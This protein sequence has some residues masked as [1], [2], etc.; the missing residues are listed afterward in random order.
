MLVAVA[1]LGL[2]LSGVLAALE[3]GRRAYAIGAARAESQ[4]GARVALDR[5]AR[6]L[7][8]AGAGPL[9]FVAISV[10]ERER[11]VLHRD[12]D[13]DGVTTAR[14]ET[15]TWTLDGTV[16]RRD[17][18]GG[19]QPVARGAT[20]FVLE[21]LDGAGQP[22]VV[23]G[24]VRSIAVTLTAEAGRGAERAGATFSTEVRL[25]NR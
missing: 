11:V 22:T 7:R 19:A 17:A 12:L 1:I 23:P 8:G 4:Q 25:R 9:P 2:T 3:S 6:E 21:Y 14:G 18:G 20:R 10:A 15:V 13:G 24:D 16:L 5:L